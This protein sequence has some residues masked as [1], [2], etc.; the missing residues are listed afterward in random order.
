MGAGVGVLSGAW[1]GPHAV[2]R[3]IRRTANPAK[4]TE[5]D[6]PIRLPQGTEA[7]CYFYY[8]VPAHVKDQAC[9]GQATGQDAL[10]REPPRV[11]TYP[12]IR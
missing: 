7:V 4:R 3:G 10:R 11:I 1:A 5:L 8:K 2:K 9:R 12:I 6:S